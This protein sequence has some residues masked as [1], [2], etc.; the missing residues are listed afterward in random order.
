MKILAIVGSKYQMSFNLQLAQVAQ[1]VV[2][3]RAEFEILDYSEVPFFDME[4]EHPAPASVTAVREKVKEADGLW[5]FT[6]EYNHYYSGYMKN[7]LD[8][9][10]RPAD[11]PTEPKPLDGKPAT[12]SGVSRGMSGASIAVDHL[13]SLLSILNMRVLYKNRVTVANAMSLCKYEAG[14]M[15]LPD[16]SRN[17]LNQQ[18]DAFLA[19]IQR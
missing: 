10:S 19:F 1:Q 15:E 7:L 14:V 13:M 11:D 16:D 6:P 12:I 2:G 5:F 17:F 9:L 8:W 4:L 3:E 18:A